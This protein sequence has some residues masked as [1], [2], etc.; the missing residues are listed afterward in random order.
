MP[1]PLIALG[2][3]A[4]G[5]F[6]AIGIYIIGRAFVSDE[7]DSRGLYGTKGRPKK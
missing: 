6:I 1:D 2:L 5:L 3:V 7:L 4:I